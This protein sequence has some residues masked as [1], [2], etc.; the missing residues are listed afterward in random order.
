M[1]KMEVE[2]GTSKGEHFSPPVL[3]NSSSRSTEVNIVVLFK[4]HYA[5]RYPDKTKF[6]N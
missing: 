6:T 2:K 3:S 5:Q 4:T 1:D